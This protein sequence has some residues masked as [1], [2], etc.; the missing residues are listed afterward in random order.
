MG[1]ADGLQKMYAYGMMLG[2]FIQVSVNLSFVQFLQT[3]LVDMI[4]S[5]LQENN[6]IQ[7]G[8]TLKLPKVR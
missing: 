6:L 3:G 7:N 8:L 2:Y 4:Y 5:I 1:I